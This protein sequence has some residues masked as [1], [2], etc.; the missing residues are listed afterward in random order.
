MI[1]KNVKKISEIA[2]TAI[3]FK[4]RAEFATLVSISNIHPFRCK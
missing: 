2:L 4:R 1:K 3:V